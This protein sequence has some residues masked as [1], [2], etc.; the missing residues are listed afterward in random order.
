MKK[1][2]ALIVG[3]TLLLGGITL[4]IQSQPLDSNTSINL[5]SEATGAT[6]IYHQLSEQNEEFEIWVISDMHH[7]ASSLREDNDELKRFV[8]S[9]DGRLLHYSKEIL[10]AFLWELAQSPPDILLVSGDLTT[11]GA[12]ASHKELAEYFYAIEAVG[13]EV[14][15]IPGNHD[16]N[17]PHALSFVGNKRAFVPSITPKEF[18]QIYWDFG[19]SSAI[20]EDDTSLSYLSRIDLTGTNHA[21]EEFYLIMLDSNSYDFNY[22]FNMPISGGRLQKD[23][24]EWL[25]GVAP[26]VGEQRAIS[27]SHHNL[28]NHAKMFSRGFDLSNAKEVRTILQRLG[29]R[30]NLSGHI[31]IQDIAYHSETG[32][33]DIA[34]GSTIQYEQGYGKMVMS[35]N[36]L[37]YSAQPVDVVGYSSATYGESDTLLRIGNLLN[38]TNFAEEYFREQSI[39][40][41][42][43]TNLEGYTAAEIDAIQEVFATLNLRHFSGR[44]G[45]DK[46]T[47]LH[48]EGYQLVEK[49]EE[50]FLKRYFDSIMAETLDDRYIEIPF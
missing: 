41:I 40:M 11:N 39:G 20:S 43:R 33:Y 9:G 31:H 24:V 1:V 35:E 28:V 42:S 13:T 14:F 44:D 36:L 10:D 18:R 48:M 16:I 37:T 7:L 47:I 5:G 4:S 26:I 25:E 15:V 27:V 12:K 22:Q 34:T 38:F 45:M 46:D 21:K 17:N 19:F 6:Q 30:V 50:G 8:E 49:M 29:V 23:T 3:V 2:G 32:I